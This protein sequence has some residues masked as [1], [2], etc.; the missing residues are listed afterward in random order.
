MVGKKKKKHSIG[1]SFIQ[2]EGQKDGDKKFHES[3]DDFLPSKYLDKYFM[4]FH[5]YIPSILLDNLINFL[6]V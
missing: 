2:D 3:L 6:P 4:C 1:K 5:S